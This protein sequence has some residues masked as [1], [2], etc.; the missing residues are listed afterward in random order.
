MKLPS[1]KVSLGMLGIASL[2]ML[3]NGKWDRW[4]GCSQ[5]VLVI[6][7]FERIVAMPYC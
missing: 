6:V 3:Y 5:Q 2:G 7:A 4:F 1:Q